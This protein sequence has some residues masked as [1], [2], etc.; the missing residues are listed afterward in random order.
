MDREHG[1]VAV[2]FGEDQG[3]ALSSGD[4]GDEG[5][6]GLRSRDGNSDSMGGTGRDHRTFALGESQA[7]ALAGSVCGSVG[8]IER[9][10]LASRRVHRSGAWRWPSEPSVT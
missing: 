10:G 5:S 7:Y 9:R 6:I 2:G 1:I 4:S 3:Y 8:N